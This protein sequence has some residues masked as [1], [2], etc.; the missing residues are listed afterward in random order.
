MAIENEDF[1]N[2]K[3]QYQQE[4][5]EIPDCNDCVFLNVTEDVQTESATFLPHVCRYYDRIVL[6]GTMKLI[7]S[8]YLNPCNECV[9][10]KFKH[11]R[12]GKDDER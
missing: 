5:V 4:P 11:Y 12:K 2:W 6:H 7:H 10:D 1:T 3:C 8:A 9:D